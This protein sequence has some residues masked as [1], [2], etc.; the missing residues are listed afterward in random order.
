MKFA[1]SVTKKVTTQKTAST[2]IREN[3]KS[4]LADY[5][6]ST[7]VLKYVMNVASLA[8]FLTYVLT[9]KV[10]DVKDVANVD[11][12]VAIVESFYAIENL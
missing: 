1:L 8:I 9:A 7:V 2:K 6:I 5:M 11:T 4:V 12:L 3:A 10:K